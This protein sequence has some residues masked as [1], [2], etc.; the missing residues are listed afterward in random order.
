M[1]ELRIMLITV[2]LGSRR[3]KRGRG[4]TS[5]DECFKCGKKGHW[6]N[7]CRDYAGRGDSRR[8]DEDSESRRK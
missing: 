6:A 1:R 5:D 2:P 7:E 8:N 4:P 3:V